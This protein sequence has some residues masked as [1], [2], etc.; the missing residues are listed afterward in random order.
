MWS[1]VASTLVS[2]T[3]IARPP[4]AL[5]FSISACCSSVGLLR[6]ALHSKAKNRPMAQA[7]MSGT[8]LRP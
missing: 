7:T 2:F 3:T 6:P 5:I 8:P 4:A 1:R